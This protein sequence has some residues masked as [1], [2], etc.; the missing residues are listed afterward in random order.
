MTAMMTTTLMICL[1]VP[2][3]GIIPMRYN[4]RPT[5]TRATMMLISPDV[6]IGRV[7]SFHDMDIVMRKI[8]FESGLFCDCVVRAL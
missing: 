5:T 7:S 2:S 3:I 8:V 1:M 4:T 6:S